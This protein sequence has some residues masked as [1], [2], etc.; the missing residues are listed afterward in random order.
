MKNFAAIMLLS[1][2]VPMILGGD[3]MGR[4]QLGNNNAYCQD[5]EISWVDWH[6][7]E[8]N[9]SLVRFFRLLIKFRKTMPLLRPETFQDNGTSAVTWHGVKLN[10]PDLEYHSRTLAML[11]IGAADGSDI[12]MVMNSYYEQ[13]RFDLP[14]LPRH[15][16]WYRI[17][18][19]N[20]APPHDIEDTDKEIVLNEQRFYNVAPRSVLILISK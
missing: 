15:K 17:V 10:K 14:Q 12:Y 8:K 16:K 3:E 4:S 19:T 18:D 6:L 1:H 20:L 7:T 11:Q 13:L 2:G 9:A 5:N